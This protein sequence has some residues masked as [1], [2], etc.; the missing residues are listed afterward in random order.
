[1]LRAADGDGSR[2]TIGRPG[3]DVELSLGHRCDLSDVKVMERLPERVPL[4]EDDRPAEP[5]LEHAQG[6]C[7]EQRRL[8]VGAG[9][10][11]LIVVATT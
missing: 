10:P 8:V 7:F 2:V 4:A 3:G 1:M 6:Q 5:G 9:P 11:H